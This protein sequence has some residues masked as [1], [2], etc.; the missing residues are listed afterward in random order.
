[1]KKYIG[2]ITIA[3][4]LTAC[5]GSDQQAA[6][7]TVP[8]DKPLVSKNTE[9]FNHSFQSLLSSY[10]AL[11]NALTDYDTTAANTA[12]VQLAS[13]SDSLPL[14][15]IKGDST[16]AIKETAASYTAAISSAAKTLV[17]EAQLEKKKR[18][19]QA[20]SDALYD[21]IRTVK[22]D[23]QKIYRQ[24]CPMAFNDEEEAY[25]ISVSDQVVNPYL[26]KKHPKYK[27]TMLEC[28]DV[29]DSLDFRNK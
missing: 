26:G 19:F 13:A 28:G 25:W 15:E 4:F 1:M 16:G 20:I 8:E 7:N 21:L 10:D 2:I 14:K 3:T 23:Q 27:A 11:R 12:S 24:H 17:T 9:A 5:G 6:E 29:A 22:Y 18:Q